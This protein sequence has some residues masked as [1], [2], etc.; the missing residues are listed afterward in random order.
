MPGAPVPAAK[1]KYS[2]MLVEVAPGHW[3]VVDHNG[4]AHKPTAGVMHHIGQMT[5]VKPYGG[6]IIT[7]GELKREGK[8]PASLTRLIAPDTVRRA[9]SEKSAKPEVHAHIVLAPGQLP[10]G[11]PRDH[12]ANAVKANGG[13]PLN[14]MPG[15]PPAALP[16]HQQAK[17]PAVGATV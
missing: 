10:P 8:V 1:P 12:P 2:Q 6:K 5:A 13:A 7:Y 3:E 15:A 16:V 11:M 17:P 14:S 9:M 4:K